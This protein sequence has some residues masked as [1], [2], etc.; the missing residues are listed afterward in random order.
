[1]PESF[2]GTSREPID[3][4]QSPVD[5]FIK[6]MQAQSGDPMQLIGM[7]AGIVKTVALQMPGVPAGVQE[8]GKV[9]AEHLDAWIAGKPLHSYAEMQARVE[10]ET[11][12]PV[13]AVESTT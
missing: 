5:A 3:P 4:N 12:A 7:L 1:M 11:P 9:F 2:R 8:T 10:G 13:V 6:V